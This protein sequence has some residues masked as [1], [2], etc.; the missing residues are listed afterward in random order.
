MDRF[1]GREACRFIE[2]YGGEGPFA[3]MVGFP[4]PHCPYDPAS[5]FPENFKP[6]DMP[7]AV[8]E[9]VGDAPKLRQ[10]NTDGNK[11]Y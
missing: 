10:Q 2:N 9:V 6:E 11:R 4:G 7:E 5:A 1:V 3:I 8:P